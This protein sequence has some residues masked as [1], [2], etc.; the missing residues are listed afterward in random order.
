[1]NGGTQNSAILFVWK[2]NS[3]SW[4]SLLCHPPLVQGPCWVS[5]PSSSDGAGILGISLI[6]FQGTFPHGMAKNQEHFPLPCKSWSPC[7]TQAPPCS[8]S[9]SDPRTFLEHFW[10]WNE[11]RSNGRWFFSFTAM[12]TEGEKAN[13]FI[14]TSLQSQIFEVLRWWKIQVI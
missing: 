5:R 6:C 13:W 1:M 7:S 4:C 2:N 10:K 8:G 12:S 3:G 11:G 14:C 9:A